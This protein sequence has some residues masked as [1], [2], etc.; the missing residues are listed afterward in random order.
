M[1]YGAVRRIPK[2]SASLCAPPAA[3]QPRASCRIL[4]PTS[5]TRPL[6]S[7]TAT[8]VE[9]PINRSGTPH[10]H[11]GLAAC[12]G[13]YASGCADSQCARKWRRRVVGPGGTSW[14]SG[15]ATASERACGRGGRQQQHEKR[16]GDRPAMDHTA[17]SLWRWAVLLAELVSPQ[18][19]TSSLARPLGRQRIPKQAREFACARRKLLCASQPRTTL[20]CRAR[21][22]TAERQTTSTSSVRS[23]CASRISRP[24]ACLSKRSGVGRQHVSY[25]TPPGQSAANHAL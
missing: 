23:P 17:A 16:G 13:A 5:T 18:H 3:W 25:V 14:V 1:A 20:G 21:T 15:S 19:G 11:A 24:V 8:S 2:Q 22:C 7:S 10:V 6:A 4:V 9:V 12:S